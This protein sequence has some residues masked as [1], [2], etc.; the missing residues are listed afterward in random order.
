MRPSLSVLC[1]GYQ[2][3]ITRLSHPSTQYAKGKS[4]EEMGRA[5]KELGL[6]RTDLV[7]TTKLFWGTRDGPNASGLSRKQYVSFL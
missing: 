4:E 2:G 3:Y 1:I 6:R 5:I 7:I